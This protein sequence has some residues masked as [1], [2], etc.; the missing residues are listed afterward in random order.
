VCDGRQSGSPS[1]ESVERESLQAGNQLRIA[2]AEVVDS[3]GTQRTGSATQLKAATK[4]GSE[5]R[6]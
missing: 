2:V 4:N 1:P 3:S 6:D 5:A